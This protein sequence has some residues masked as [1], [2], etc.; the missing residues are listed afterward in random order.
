M[1]DGPACGITL[2]ALAFVNATVTAYGQKNRR[3]PG[4]LLVC[5]SNCVHK[6]SGYHERAVGI[7][8]IVVS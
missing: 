4:I 7:K 2:N 6:T 1:R 3:S 5:G 8:D